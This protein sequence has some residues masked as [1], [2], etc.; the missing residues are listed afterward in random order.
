[1][2]NYEKF[3]WEQMSDNDLHQIVNGGKK[4]LTSYQLR[5]IEE[6]NKRAIKN[7]IQ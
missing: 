1:M 5:A 3:F 6:L 7:P 4:Y 2:M